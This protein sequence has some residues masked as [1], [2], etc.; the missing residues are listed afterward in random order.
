[1]RAFV[2]DD[3]KDLLEYRK[4]V[5]DRMAN[6]SWK[7]RMH[8]DVFD[9]RVVERRMADNPLWFG[10]TSFEEMN[11]GINTFQN[12]E[13]ITKIY[14]QVSDKISSST[15]DRIKAKKVKYN[16]NGL[17]VFVFDRAAMGMYRMSEFY[18]P[19]LHQVV[20]ERKV[21]TTKDRYT[22]K[23]D[24]SP[25]INRLEECEDGRPKIRTT[26][27]NVFAYYP[28][29]P[30]DN[31]AVELLI[32]CGGHVGVTSEQLLY[33]GISALVVAQMLE[34]A[35]VKTRI[36]VVFGSS[37]DG[38]K[39]SSYAAIVPVKNYDENLDI[40]LLA[41]LSSDPRFFRFE[42]FKGIIAGYDHFNA[43]CPDTLGK[44]MNRDYL[45]QTIEDSD[46]AQKTNLSPNR[47]YFGWTFSEADALKTISESVNQIAE[48]I[49]L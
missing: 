10:K 44:G 29:T 37:P 14:N 32:S 33:S 46:Y 19:S 31:K 39:S 12:P 38:Y 36:S 47:F 9:K 49:G 26:S 41:L 16:P 20:D 4:W 27:K 30:K 35:K 22:L 28:P 40:N 8:A 43:A 42:G 5:N 1:M 24:G 21:E 48:R 34:K 23:E 18:S 3:F 7:N 17:G 6:L 15:K 2:K 25:V 11:T 13:L 45:R